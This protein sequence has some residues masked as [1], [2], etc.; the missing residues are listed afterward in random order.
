VLSTSRYLSF[1]ISLL[2]SSAGSCSS[3]ERTR[4]RLL[5]GSPARENRI[6]KPL[7]RYDRD[8]G[9]G[10]ARP[11]TIRLSAES[12]YADGGNLGLRLRFV[13]GRLLR[14]HRCALED[15]MCAVYPLYLEREIDRRWLH[16]LVPKDRSMPF[17]RPKHPNDIRP[18]PKRPHGRGN[19]VR[20]SE[21]VK[22]D[23]D[24]QKPSRREQRRH[25]M[26]L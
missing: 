13:L 18:L 8:R 7:R 11:S 5:T 2:K 14:A 9:R 17:N 23:R 10:R 3:P 22:S 6:R 25:L 21:L 24:E 15:P 26:E 4:P 19:L 20:K 12:N 16:R 1:A